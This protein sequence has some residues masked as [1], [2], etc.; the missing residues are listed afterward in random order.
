MVFRIC[1]L[2]AATSLWRAQVVRRTTA[3]AS[4]GSRA[5]AVTT[6][7]SSTSS[8][9]TPRTLQCVAC[10]PLIWWRLWREWGGKRFSIICRVRSLWW[11]CKCFAL[12]SRTSWRVVLGHDATRW[13]KHR[14]SLLS[15]G[16]SIRS[17]IPLLLYP[18]LLTTPDVSLI[19]P[20][21]QTTFWNYMQSFN[22]LLR[23][24]MSQKLRENGR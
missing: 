6:P 12:S 7:S 10:R 1:K 21:F 5:C 24:L 16:D 19:L 4:S 14:T 23:F 20:S 8:K 22:D 9:W 11:T 17:V 3:P 15:H 2:E 13:R 18:L